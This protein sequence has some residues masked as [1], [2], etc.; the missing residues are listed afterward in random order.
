MAE[1]ENQTDVSSVKEAKVSK[2][3]IIY[4]VGFDIH[5]EI[6]AREYF[7]HQSYTLSSIDKFNP[8]EMLKRIYEAVEKDPRC[9]VMPNRLKSSND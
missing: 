2:L 8:N 7:S 4:H 6:N 5:V 3:D 9:K 1:M